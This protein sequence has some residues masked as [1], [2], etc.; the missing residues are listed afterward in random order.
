M[1]L[2]KNELFFFF[3][4]WLC[5]KWDLSSLTRDQSHTLA[6]EAWS[7]NPGPP[8]E[9]PKRALAKSSVCLK[10]KKRRVTVEILVSIL[11]TMNKRSKHAI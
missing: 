9:V 8:R 10:K 1:L 3:L 7:L 4:I 11:V 2:W 5:G 6:L